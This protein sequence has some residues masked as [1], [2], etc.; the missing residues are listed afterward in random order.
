ML[1][2]PGRGR[3]PAPQV[4]GVAGGEPASEETVMDMRSADKIEIISV[5]IVGGEEQ[6]RTELTMRRR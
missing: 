5:E 2:V 1:R 4:G 6:V 3:R